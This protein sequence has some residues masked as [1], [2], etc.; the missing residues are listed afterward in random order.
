[1]IVWGNL[2]QNSGNLSFYWIEIQVNHLLSISK[3]MFDKDLE[4][5]PYEEDMPTV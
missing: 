2:G 4:D 1:M 5:A 3:L